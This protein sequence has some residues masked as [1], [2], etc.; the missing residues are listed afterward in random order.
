[1]I[2]ID[3]QGWSLLSWLLNIDSE[4]NCVTETSDNGLVAAGDAQEIFLTVLGM[5][6]GCAESIP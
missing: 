5:G 1:M 2:G 4:F 3:Q 6:A